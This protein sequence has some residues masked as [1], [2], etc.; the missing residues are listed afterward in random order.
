MLSITKEIYQTLRK[1]EFKNWIKK[2][3]NKI[4]IVGTILMILVILF[5]GFAMIKP[6]QD[7]IESL[8]NANKYILI[9]IG[10][11]ILYVFGCAYS[12]WNN[13]SLKSRKLN[14]LLE[15][16]KKTNLK[17][18]LL[19]FEYISICSCIATTIRYL[20]SIIIALMFNAMLA[21]SN[22]ELED[23]QLIYSFI[24]DWILPF[25]ITMQ[26]ATI[27]NGFVFKKVMIILNFDWLIKRK[28]KSL[29]K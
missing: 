19:Q 27:V 24:Y 4:K 2:D 20:S 22:I 11:S 29:Y 14:H 15:N 25:I 10:L 26:I 9:F 17:S 21:Y 28:V 5:S 18:E 8:I 3:E 7:L 12:Q 1:K 6:T 23:S 13:I 16:T